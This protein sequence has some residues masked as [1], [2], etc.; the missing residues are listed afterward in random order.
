MRE[1]LAAQAPRRASKIMTTLALRYLFLIACSVLVVWGQNSSQSSTQS[2]T[3]SSSQS[4]TQNASPSSAPPTATAP[5]PEAPTSSAGAGVDPKSYRIGPEDILFVQVWR[6]PDFTRQVAVRPDGKITMPLIG[7]LQAGGMTPIETGSEISKALNKY[8]NTP[9][10]SVTVVQ[11][12]SKKY[13]ITGEVM[14]TGAFP[15]AVPTT[16]LQALSQAGGFK[17]FANKKKIRILRGNKPMFFN[18]NDVVKGKHP[19]QNILLDP[20]DYIIVD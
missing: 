7:E 10:V 19:E 13:Y 4:A 5:K 1:P 9:D 16:V 18:Y 20:G 14:K 15:L 17:E 12:N 3:P 11:V 8:I 2:A 6:E